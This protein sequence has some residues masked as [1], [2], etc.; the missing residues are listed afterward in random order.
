MAGCQVAERHRITLF[1]H[2]F[3]KRLQTFV[4]DKPEGFS[5]QSKD[6]SIAIY[7]FGGLRLTNDPHK[8]LHKMDVYLSRSDIVILQL[9]SNDI[10]DPLYE[11]CTFV[12]DYLS[13]VQ[14][15]IHGLGIKTVC[16]C[17]ILPRQ[18]VPYENYNDH[19]IRVNVLL[20]QQITLIDSVYFWKHRAGLWNPAANIYMPDGIHLSYDLGYTKYFRS[21]R[22]CIFRLIK[23]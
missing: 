16:V 7:G 3:F 9:G 2:S 15:L 13:Y 1:G 11:P 20:Q 10:C 8:R 22:D 12:R 19:V 6:I 17:Q 21:L 5:I 18:T 23:W 14:F 4:N